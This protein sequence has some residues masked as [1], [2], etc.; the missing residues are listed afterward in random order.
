MRAA[1]ISILLASALSACESGVTVSQTYL[2]Q[3]GVPG[4]ADYAATQG[5]TP[6]VMLNQPFPP[7]TVAAA[8]Q[9]NNPRPLLFTTEPPASLQG[10]YRVLLAFGGRPAGG[11][12]VCREPLAAAPAAATAT[13]SADTSVYG[14]FCLGPALLSEAVASTPRID[15]PADPRFGRMMG[16]LLSALMPMHE[17]HEGNRS[18]CVKQ[19]C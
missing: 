15:S 19:P 1:L 4:H 2:A 16:D 5:A 12:Y 3:R 18:W 6:V 10:G 13:P 7:L 17:L 8:M 11:L 9:K 14:A